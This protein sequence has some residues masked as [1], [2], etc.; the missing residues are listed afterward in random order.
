MP[1]GMLICG[2]PSQRNQP[3]QR[4]TF[5]QLKTKTSKAIEKQ[6]NPC[7]MIPPSRYE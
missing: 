1:A 5:Q 7:E 2:K 6:S 4:V 3:A